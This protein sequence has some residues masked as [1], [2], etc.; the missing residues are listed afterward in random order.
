LFV[1]FVL[2]CVVSKHICQSPEKEE[3]YPS[4]QSAVAI[5]WELT[6]Q[7]L[8]SGLLQS[9][10][11]DP[12]FPCSQMTLTAPCV[13]SASVP[14]GLTNQPDLTH[15]QGDIPVQVTASTW[16]LSCWKDLDPR[17]LPGTDKYTRCPLEFHGFPLKLMTI[18]T[19]LPLHSL[20][21]VEQKRGRYTHTHT[22]THA[23]SSPWLL[24]KGCQK[25]CVCSCMGPWGP[26]HLPVI[27]F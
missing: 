26:K 27:F 20:S 8:G 1:C 21:W 6:T 16:M 7:A 14:P 11:T 3:T 5:K 17:N 10:L 23:Q 12:S 15:L 18:E 13:S 22:H 19:N 2:C 25:D 9:V 4:P 24:N